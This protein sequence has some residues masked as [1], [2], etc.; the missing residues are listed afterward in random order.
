MKE[1][2]KV[3][4]FLI[5]IVIGGLIVLIT[6]LSPLFYYRCKITYDNTKFIFPWTCK[7]EYNWKYIPEEL[8]KKAFEQNINLKNQ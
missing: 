5:T 4:L 2:L 7:V 1:D 6:I 8:Y 3:F